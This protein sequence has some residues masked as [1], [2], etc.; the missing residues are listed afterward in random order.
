M[1]YKILWYALFIKKFVSIPEHVSYINCFQNFELTRLKLVCDY[2]FIY[3]CCCYTSDEGIDGEALSCLTERALESLV[4]RA[5]PLMKLLK[6]IKGMEK[7]SSV[8]EFHSDLSSAGSLSSA[9]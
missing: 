8:S 2:I 3:S 5:G 9:S 6:I 7:G 1:V 4:T